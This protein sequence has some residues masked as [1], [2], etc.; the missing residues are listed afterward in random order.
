ML[1]NVSQSPVRAV[2][3]HSIGIGA[4]AEALK[5]NCGGSGKASRN[6]S[7]HIVTS[8][9][10]RED[11][12]F[13]FFF[14]GHEPPLPTK[15]TG[16][17]FDKSEVNQPYSIHGTS[18]VPAGTSAAMLN[19]NTPLACGPL[20]GKPIYPLGMRS[21]WR[22]TNSA[23]LLWDKDN[24]PVPVSCGILAVTRSPAKMVRHAK[25]SRPT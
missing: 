23:L 13:F 2:T 24:T 14:F 1:E 3:V 4:M 11:T 17:F 20:G 7:T 25:A 18:D 8:G 9:V 6:N 21:S 16:K 5:R 19:T 15:L 12:T 22:K 10:G